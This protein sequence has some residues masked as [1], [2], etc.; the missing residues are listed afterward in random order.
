MYT[1]IRENVERIVDSVDKAEALVKE[2]FRYVDKEEK[3][4]VKESDNNEKVNDKEEK[5]QC[6][7]TADKVSD[8]NDNK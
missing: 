7:K 5:K 2:G 8:L 4:E 1:L 3:N 6:K